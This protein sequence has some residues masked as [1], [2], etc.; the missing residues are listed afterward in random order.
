MGFDERFAGRMTDAEA[1]IR[2][3][4][5]SGN[6][7]RAR[8]LASAAYGSEA[9]KLSR[10]RPADSAITDAQMAA[11]ELAAAESLK[12]FKPARPGNRRGI[13]SPRELLAAFDR[14][15]AKA[16]AEAQS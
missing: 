15:L 11:A 7:R 4:L 13:P 10:R 5:V 9:R 1:G 2:A 16:R 14:T 12:T 3:A 6:P 8:H